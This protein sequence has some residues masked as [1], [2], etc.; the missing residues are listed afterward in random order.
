MSSI[1]NFGQL[2][3]LNFKRLCCKGRNIIDENCDLTVRN[4]TIRNLSVP[5]ELI[6]DG[7]LGGNKKLTIGGG[8]IETG[9]IFTN[10]DEHSRIAYIDGNIGNVIISPISD[11]GL[12]D[13]ETIEIL[14]EPCDGN[15]VLDGVSGNVFYEPLGNVLGE[16]DSYQYNITDICG[17]NHTITQY[18][19][20]PSQRM[21]PFLNPCCVNG[22]FGE[23]DFRAWTSEDAFGGTNSNW[24]PNPD[25]K[26]VTQTSTQDGGVS[27]FYSDFN[28]GACQ[29]VEIPL[30]PTINDND[31][32]GFA[33]GFQPNY[34]TNTNA[35]F[36]LIDWKGGSQSFDFLDDCA[37]TR[38]SSVGLAVSRVFGTPIRTEYWAHNNETCNG[39]TNGLEEIARA[40]TLGSTGWVLNQTYV[41]RI[42]YSTKYLKVWVDNVL[43]L[44]ITPP[45]GTTF[46]E[47][48]LGLYNFSQTSQYGN[49]SGGSIPIIGYENETTFWA[50]FQPIIPISANVP[51]QI[52]LGGGSTAELVTNQIINQVDSHG[53][54]GV[55]QTGLN[56]SNLTT[57][58]QSGI[59]TSTDITI[60]YSNFNL[61]TSHNR[62]FL[63]IGAISQPSL[64]VIITSDPP[65]IRQTWPALGSFPITI[66]SGTPNIT[67]IFWNP[68]TGEITSPAAASGS[69]HSQA[70]VLDLGDLSQYN[71]ITI[72]IPDQPA[73]DGII[74]GIGEEFNSHTLC[75]C[76]SDQAIEGSAPIDPSSVVI[77]RIEEPI[78]SPTSE[79]VLFTGWVNYQDPLA[80]SLIPVVWSPNPSVAT[81][82]ITSTNN[83]NQA[84]LTSP[85]LDLCEWNIIIST[86][87]L[88]DDDRIGFTIGFNVGDQSSSAANYLVVDWVGAAGTRMY[89]QEGIPTIG[90]DGLVSSFDLLEF[91]SNF[92]STG[93]TA[94]VTY[95]WRFQYCGERLKVY[96]E[97][98]LEFDILY[99]FPN[100][101]N[102]GILTTSQNTTYNECYKWTNV[103]CPCTALIPD[104]DWQTSGNV[105]ANVDANGLLTIISDNI[106][107]AARIGVIIDDTL[108]QTS[109]EIFVYAGFK[110]SEILQIPEARVAMALTGTVEFDHIITFEFET[111]IGQPITTNE[112]ITIEV[113]MDGVLIEI[114]TGMLN[115]NFSTFTTTQTTSNKSLLDHI[116]TD[117]AVVDGGSVVV[118]TANFSA[119]NGAIDPSVGE[120]DITLTVF[121]ANSQN[122]DNFITECANIALLMSGYVGR[123]GTE[124]GTV[125]SS[126]A[127]SFQ[128]YRIYDVTY[129]NGLTAVVST[130]P[131]VYNGSVGIQ[132]F[133]MI[134]TSSVSQMYKGTS[135]S[136]VL[137]NNS[138]FFDYWNFPFV[139]GAQAMFTFS[140]PL[141]KIGFVFG[142]M[143]V[144][145][146]AS[147]YEINPPADARSSTSTTRYGTSS[148]G[149]ISV[150][151]A[152]ENNAVYLYWDTPQTTYSYFFNEQFSIGSYP[153][154]IYCALPA[155]ATPS[156]HNNNIARSGFAQE[157]STLTGSSPFRAIDGN[158]NGAYF[159]GSVTH[160]NSVPN[161]WW[162][163]WFSTSFVTSVTL[164]NRTD[165][166]Q[167]RLTNFRLSLYDKFDN[168]VFGQNYFTS[169]GIITSSFNIPINATGN[170]V[171]VQLLGNNRE[172]N[173]ILSLAE[174]QVFV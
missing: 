90:G 121:V 69:P 30:R 23:I 49:F 84:F 106:P 169:S 114:I 134:P 33:L 26:S 171:R 25:G 99:V 70:I 154:A 138:N 1:K 24:T 132:Q 152:S 16:I 115:S 137:S 41:F 147:I 56:Y 117:A 103:S 135:S 156:V 122:P 98:R 96:I 165:C 13:P 112:P 89:K 79:Q 94:G 50:N 148:S 53:T 87:P 174:V 127:G 51:S 48:R 35:E 78:A 85:D 14:N 32:I 119:Y 59:N 129:V 155:I 86:R 105:I 150:R 18:I 141:P 93:W 39:P 44:D 71:S 151:S 136:D 160:T 81:T 116:I 157:S 73:G 173:G 133:Y 19:C 28:F 111:N 92:G 75:C 153:I 128:M 20:R 62:G 54:L 21:P 11:G 42:E 123:A 118:R 126:P 67:P 143:D 104:V 166:C 97:D 34:T 107:Q 146:G 66:F 68:L 47:G 72:T 38:A 63:L 163:V 167:L 17:L 109:N 3:Y 76:V 15:I 22:C 61:S 108:G 161:S 83:G 43:Q 36:L 110:T 100:G 144:S 95:V 29:T 46:P 131:G 164:W 145:G 130:A 65:G 52:P 140:Q 149:I 80:F 162:Q 168:E 64:P 58:T 2:P 12:F 159:S 91:G 88:D 172:G 7:T 4:G 9:T 27:F 74:H 6:V 124:N 120:S 55:S 45:M 77:T 102:F 5:N 60:V 142:D 40:N 101:V 10:E 8:V 31:F 170:R 37:P 139:E 82:S 158:T 125:I 57:F 113:E